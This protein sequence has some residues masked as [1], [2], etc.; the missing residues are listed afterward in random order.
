MLEIRKIQIFNVSKA[1]NCDLW[2]VFLLALLYNIKDF[3][4]PDK[5]TE[6]LSI[7]DIRKSRKDG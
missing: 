7:K 4:K 3:E 5:E 1:I 2:L 6:N